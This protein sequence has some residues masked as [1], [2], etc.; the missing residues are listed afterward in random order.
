MWLKQFNNI[1]YT[2]LR[3]F[4][5]CYQESLLEASK[6]R[7]KTS[8]STWRHAVETKSGACENESYVYLLTT[9]IEFQ[10]YS[11]V[12]SAQAVTNPSTSPRGNG[13]TS[14][15]WFISSLP[16]LSLRPSTHVCCVVWRGATHCNTTRDEKEPGFIKGGPSAQSL[17]LCFRYWKVFYWP[18]V[19]HNIAESR[20]QSSGP[21]IIYVKWFR[22]EMCLYE[23]SC[24]HVNKLIL[25]SLFF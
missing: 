10:L 2:F 1:P 18:R 3:K 17:L 12:C 13:I 9:G 14:A 4:N 25:F 22:G 20:M 15:K 5:T 16:S 23:T 11:L 24:F 21:I 19:Q 7:K 8:L 6:T